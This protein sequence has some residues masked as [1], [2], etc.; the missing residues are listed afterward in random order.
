MLHD[1][2]PR[3]P[4][5]AEVKWLAYRLRESAA[6]VVAALYLLENEGRA[7]HTSHKYL[8]KLLVT[9][10]NE[11]KPSDEDHCLGGQRT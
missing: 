11:V 5:L 1:F 8:W 10:T 7:C 6:D 4:V 9:P 2:S 3:E